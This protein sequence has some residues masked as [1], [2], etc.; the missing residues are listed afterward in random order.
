[1]QQFAV[2]IPINSDNQFPSAWYLYVVAI[3]ACHR[4]WDELMNLFYGNLVQVETFILQIKFPSLHLP[5]Q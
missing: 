4:I 3:Q 1:M 5:S 2:K